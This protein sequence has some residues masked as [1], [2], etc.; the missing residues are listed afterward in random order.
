MEKAAAAGGQR[1]PCGDVQDMVIG[2]QS[3]TGGFLLGVS[4]YQLAENAIQH[5]S[6]FDLR[7]SFHHFPPPLPSSLKSFGARKK[8]NMFISIQSGF[9]WIFQTIQHPT[10]FNSLLC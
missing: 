9:L 2:N 6:D 10:P 4:K 8:T 3:N 5:K 1:W 7:T